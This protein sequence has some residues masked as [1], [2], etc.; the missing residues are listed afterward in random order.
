MLERHHIVRQR[1]GINAVEPHFGNGKPYGRQDNWG[2]AARTTRTSIVAAVI[3]VSCLMKCGRSKRSI[4]EILR[5]EPRQMLSV[6]SLAAVIDWDRNL[7]DRRPHCSSGNQDN[8]EKQRRLA[9]SSAHELP[10]Y[11]QQRAE[12]RANGRLEFHSSRTRVL[13]DPI[14]QRAPSLLAASSVFKGAY[15]RRG[16]RELRTVRVGISAPR[17]RS[18]LR[19]GSKP[20]HHNQCVPSPVDGRYAPLP[21]PENP[22]GSPKHDRANTRANHKIRVR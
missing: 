14:G 8:R 13:V 1:V 18:C 16:H 5:T 4:F 3:D 12:S 19:P 9:K 10:E 17:L 11:D 2:Q 21:K 22:N 6:V 20:T 15:C 7:D